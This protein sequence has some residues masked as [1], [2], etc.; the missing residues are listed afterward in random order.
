VPLVGAVGVGALTPKLL[1]QLQRGPVGLLQ[2]PVLQ[3]TDVGDNV[4][5]LKVRFYGRLLAL[6]ERAAPSGRALGLTLEGLIW[7]K[8]YLLQ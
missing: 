6:G 1:K 3:K 2:H 7:S 5:Q 4:Q 8:L